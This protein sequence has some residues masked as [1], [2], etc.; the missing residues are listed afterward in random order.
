MRRSEEPSDTRLGRLAWRGLILLGRVIGPV[1]ARHI[2][3]HI[4]RTRS[5]SLAGYVES[6]HRVAA[7]H[8]WPSTPDLV[9]LPEAWWR[10]SPRLRVR[11]LGFDLDL[12]LRDNLQRV[13]YYTGRYEPS[14]TRLLRRELRPGDVVVD[15]GAHIGVHAL[16]AA[17]RLRELGDGHVYA[18]EPSASADT[19]ERVARGHGLSLTVVRCALGA[20]AGSLELKT[21]TGY[22]AADAGV[23]SQYGDG[24]GRRVP[25]QVFDV[26]ATEAGLSRLDIV[27]I[28]VE[29]AEPLVL[30][31]M[32]ASL[33]R[34][35]PRAIIIELKHAILRR[36]GTSVEEVH[37]VLA[38]ARYVVAAELE[39]SNVVYRPAETSETRLVPGSGA[40][41]DLVKYD[42]GRISY[43]VSVVSDD[44]N[45]LVVRAPWIEEQPR[46]LGF[47]VFEPGDVFTEHYWRDRWYSIKE[48]RHSDGAL[49]G[50]YCDVTR[51]VQV[52]PDRVVSADL[53]LDLWV[54]SAGPPI[55]LDED[56][57]AESGLAA[58]DSIASPAWSALAEL[59]RLAADQ[60]A[61]WRRDV[62]AHPDR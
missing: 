16:T 48:V 60:F 35:R 21:S 2:A 45:H 19:L 22:D 24:R 41:V 13:L 23:L 39:F 8:T 32:R 34:L 55:R 1:A 18:F 53:I 57:F 17:R 15:V 11:R 46:N 7:R 12:D 29:G 26:W 25:V 30:A 40:T 27:K 36:G 14:V 28:D 58:D 61:G 56:E 37:R 38:D 52:L 9:H 3:A 20:Q 31:G 10:A 62:T 59:E 51:P 4:L 42:G 44:G 49:K 43:D 50:W 33:E 5:R 6:V 47:A 54:P